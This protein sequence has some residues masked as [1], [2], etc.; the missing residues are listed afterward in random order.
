MTSLPE[1]PC[2]TCDGTG[3]LGG[4]AKGAGPICPDC[5]GTGKERHPALLPPAPGLDALRREV[6]VART[7]VDD[8]L[9]AFAEDPSL[10]QPDDC[11]QE[12]IARVHWQFDRD[13]RA[14]EA[15]S[16]ALGRA[17]G[18]A[19]GAAEREKLRDALREIAKRGKS[20]RALGDVLPALDELDVLAAIQEMAERRALLKHQVA[21]TVA[22][23]EVE[24]EAIAAVLSRWEEIGGSEEG[25][26]TPS[27]RK[28]LQ[29]LGL[30]AVMEAMDSAESNWNRKH[31]RSEADSW[32]Y[33][34]GACWKMVRRK[35][36]QH[37]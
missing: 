35:Q 1:P 11:D 3:Q 27:A 26:D 25:F 21:A 13:L 31:W 32:R 14:Y 19:E 2:S 34:C 37:E 12:A 10:L 15:P 30:P 28:F 6:H 36:G 20:A 17:L 18:R 22:Q 24:N 9:L 5:R 29:F 4:P 8:W 23:R 16:E 33:F 7:K